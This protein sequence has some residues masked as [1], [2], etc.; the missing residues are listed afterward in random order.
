[1]YIP[2]DSEYNNSRVINY[3]RWSDCKE[4]DALVAVLLVNIKSRKKSGYK[5]ALKVL[6][7]DLY[8]SYVTDTEQYIGYFRDM[9]H[10]HFKSKVGDGDRYIINPHIAYP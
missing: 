2:N 7:L 6:L 4:V 1:M 9:D 8:Q 10:Y 5:N 3:N